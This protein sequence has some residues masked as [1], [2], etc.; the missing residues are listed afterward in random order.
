GDDRGERRVHWDRQLV[1]GLK[2]PDL[3]CSIADML[4]AHAHDIRTPLTSVEQEGERQAGTR[5]DHMPCLELLDFSLG[6]AVIAVRLTLMTFT[7]RVGSSERSP[8][9]TACCIMARS[10]L[11]RPF[12]LPGFSAR[13]AMSLTM[14]SRCRVAARLSPCS[15]Q[16]R[17]IM[18]R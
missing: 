5:T 13:A 16:K 12:A 11:C 2:L 15:L 3:Q 8:V 14:C 17:S 10:T 9:S 7:S 18:R 4:P 1:T 6:P